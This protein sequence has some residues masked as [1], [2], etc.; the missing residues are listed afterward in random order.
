MVADCPGADTWHVTSSLP[1][2]VHR[3]AHAAALLKQH[4]TATLQKLSCRFWPMQEVAFLRP[5]ASSLLTRRKKAA[6]RE[7]RN[8]RST[9]LPQCH[10]RTVSCGVPLS[11]PKMRTRVVCISDTHG[12]QDRFDE[13]PDGDVLLHAGDF[14]N[15]G[16]PEEVAK[17][18]AFLGRLPHKE[19]IVI[20]G[21]HDV[22]FHTEFYEESWRNFHH[23]YTPPSKAR[24]LLTNCTYLEDSSTVVKGGWKVYGSPWSPWFY[25]W[26]FQL[27]RGAEIRQKWELIPTDTDILM[28]H[29]PP[30][31]FRDK[32]LSGKRVGCEDLTD[33]VLNRV[34]PMY[35][36]F[37]HIHEDHGVTSNSTTVFVNASS[38]R[39][40]G[41]NLN[42]PIV[43]EL[44]ERNAPVSSLQ[45]QNTALR[46]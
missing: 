8:R 39:L 36:V 22:S 17:F 35:H 27:Q 42:E 6:A 28:T 14:T 7:R 34:R 25:D 23:K 2:R 13:I 32:I 38:C 45:Y 37:G 4:N 20:A 19:K 41:K 33:V 26:A 11:P 3:L 18:N 1:Q 21:N 40:F 30:A 15:M 31:G 10:S 44:E 16:K 29:G 5:T 24:E 12:F 9:S 43:F 46:D